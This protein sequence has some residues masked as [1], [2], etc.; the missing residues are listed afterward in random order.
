MKKLF[1]FEVNMHCVDIP[2]STWCK[3]KDCCQT[4]HG[5]HLCTVLLCKTDS[6]DTNANTK[7]ETRGCSLNQQRQMD[8]TV[9][10]KGKRDCLIFASSRSWSTS[11]S[12]I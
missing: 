4:S 1:G 9:E 11:F 5:C 7:R 12:Y 3:Q 2:S 6:K 8:R 10:K